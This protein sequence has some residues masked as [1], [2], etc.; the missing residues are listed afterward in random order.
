MYVMQVHTRT[1]WASVADLEKML[2]KVP[3]AL[4]EVSLY[5]ISRGKCETTLGYVSKGRPGEA[6][7]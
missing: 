4:E 1:G 3:W 7:V 6:L 2:H 5:A